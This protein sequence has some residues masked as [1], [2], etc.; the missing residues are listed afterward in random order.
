MTAMQTTVWKHPPETEQR[1]RCA[2]SKRKLVS[3]A[4][5][6]AYRRHVRD[7]MTRTAIRQALG[8]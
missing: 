6:E 8:T 2:R 3:Q 5:R 1:Q 7:S 4:L